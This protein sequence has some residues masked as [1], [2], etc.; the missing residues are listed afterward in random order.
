MDQCHNAWI[1][2]APIQGRELWLGR[3]WLLG[4]V[5]LC[6]HLQG[7]LYTSNDQSKYGC[8][9]ITFPSEARLPASIWTIFL[10]H[11]PAQSG[12]YP[13]LAKSWFQRIQ[14]LF[15][16][17]FRPCIIHM[18]SD[19]SYIIHLGEFHP[20]FKIQFNLYRIQWFNNWMCYVHYKRCYIL[21]TYYADINSSTE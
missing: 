8:W 21:I 6:T 16:S 1:P 9:Y 15:I 11:T 12:T 20:Y 7:H 17:V 3:N 5:R 13:R 19:L 10:I 2:V 18:T 14:F 4:T